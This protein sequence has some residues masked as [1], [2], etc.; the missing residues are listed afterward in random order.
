MHGD[1]QRLQ[2]LIN[3]S[4]IQDL[5]LLCQPVF[6]AEKV[7]C[8][9]SADVFVLP[10]YHEGMPISVIEAMA[11]GLPVVATA[12]GGIP[13][14]ISDGENGLL[15]MPGEPRQLAEALASLI[16]DPGTRTRMGLAGRQR[17]LARHDLDGTVP[18][19][20]RFHESVAAAHREQRP[21]GDQLADPGTGQH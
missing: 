14:L 13:D 11:S 20:M 2:D 5:I 18:D 19:L 7:A 6:D 16:T 21:H 1:Q 3:E 15:V 10:S 12:V 9:A 8:L 4:G 17:A